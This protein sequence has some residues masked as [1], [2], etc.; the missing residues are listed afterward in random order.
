LVFCILDLDQIQRFLAEPHSAELAVRRLASD[1]KIIWP[2]TSAF[3]CNPFKDSDVHVIEASWK[4]LSSPSRQHHNDLRMRDHG[5][6]HGQVGT[7]LVSSRLHL[8][9]PTGTATASFIELSVVAIQRVLKFPV[10]TKRLNASSQ[11]NG[12]FSICVPAHGV[13]RWLCSLRVPVDG[14]GTAFHLS[15]NEM[16]ESRSAL[17]IR[18][19]TSDADVSGVG[20][21][22]NFVKEF[23]AEAGKYTIQNAAMAL[24][25]V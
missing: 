18:L 9:N 24:T 15:S 21:T 10:L 6:E 13:S 5:A 1:Q 11:L 8:G 22:L 4:V 7:N 19:A 16:P 3:G 12:I 23:S 2:I 17:W 25:I 20:V 14:A